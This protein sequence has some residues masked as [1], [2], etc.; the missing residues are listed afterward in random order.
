MRALDP[1]SDRPPYRQVMD[2]IRDAI[3]AGEF[4]PGDRIPTREA[5]MA[6]FGVARQTIQTAI[7]GLIDQGVI[8]GEQ[9]RG[10]FVAG[11]GRPTPDIRYTPAVRAWTCGQCGALIGDREQH[12]DWHSKL[13]REDA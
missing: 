10:M 5:L 9:G 8:I 6:H 13:T 7:R 3:A 2:A 4:T 1:A 11:P 12:T